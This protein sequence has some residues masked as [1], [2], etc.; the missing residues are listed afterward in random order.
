MKDVCLEK[1]Q[2][3]FI[4]W[5]EKRG[6][7]LMAKAWLRERW[8]T[9]IPA[10]ESLSSAQETEI[11]RLCAEEIDAWKARPSM[12]SLSSLKEPMTDTRNRIREI[13]VT[14]QNSYLNPRTGERE[15]L[16]LKYLNYN[17]REWAEMN[18]QSEQRYHERLEQ[19]Q[20]LEHPERIVAK[21]GEL[22]GSRS[23]V[24]VVVGLAVV[25]GRRLSEILKTGELHPKTRYTVM[26][27]GHLKRK[28]VVLKPYEIPVL[29]EASVVLAAW[30]RLRSL[31]D[32][33]Q[34][35]T[36]AIG[37]TYGVEIGAAA[38]RHFAGLVPRR[39][40]RE[41]LFAHV[42]RAV[43]PRLAVYYFCPPDVSD[44][45]Y[46]STILGHYW[47][48]TA[49]EAQQRN[50]I[51]S[52]HY[53][54]YKVGDGTGN[55]DG[56]Q[57]I[58]LGE[59]GVEVLDVFKPKPVGEQVVR[60]Q[61]KESQ[62][63]RLERRK[64][65]AA[66]RL[67]QQ[68]KA[69]LD[70]MQHE[71]GVRTQDEAISA[72]LDSYYILKQIVE[73]LRPTYAHLEVDDPLR[74]VQWLVGERNTVQVDQQL[75]ELFHTSFSGVR[76]LLEDAA[77]ESE[78]PVTYLQELLAAKRSFKKSYE[79][80]HQGKDYTRLSLT[81]LRNTKTPGAAQERYRRAVEAIMAYNDRVDMPELRWYIN[82]A[83]V[84]DLV[85]GRP[86]DV[87]AYLESRQEEIAA[88]HTKYG[89]TPG[90]NRRPISITARITVPERPLEP[91]RNEEQVAEE[92]PAEVARGVEAD[93]SAEMWG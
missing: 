84:V 13:P 33:S 71:L 32:C 67:R 89:L 34:M 38:E 11:A 85:G 21:A 66:T 4:R 17:E 61:R 78:Y 29:I 79:K 56:R 27:A 64:G 47:T 14:E 53:F 74:A 24:E 75:G 93:A 36:E 15:H 60:T 59:P 44:L 16:A 39:H 9:L 70:Q 40:G 91:E 54:D 68:T 8:K 20:L 3:M 25:T 49:D 12:Q 62:V 43:Y 55:I 63:E 69:R 7:R 26:F 19:Q 52:L 77:K 5:H 1:E 42:F 48:A 6:A 35:E 76:A 82:P 41:K 50:Y 28:D 10:L 86:A 57:G 92:V 18:R 81:E 23:W 46:V 58:R 72:A 73:L 22:L 31:V 51:S 2:V 37:K 87:K 90:Y 65:H 45:A 88:H 80:R 30:Q 83:V